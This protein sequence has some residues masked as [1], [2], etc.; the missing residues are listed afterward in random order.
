MEGNISLSIESIKKY[1]NA[2]D[3]C[4]QTYYSACVVSLKVWLS[5]VS[6]SKDNRHAY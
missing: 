3:C 6:K 5:V 1:R 4:A 2:R